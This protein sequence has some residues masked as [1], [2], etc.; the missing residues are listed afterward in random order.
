M[1]RVCW[2]IP[3]LSLIARLQDTSFVAGPHTVETGEGKQR[4][5]IYNAKRK[6][7]YNAKRRIIYNAKRRIIYN[8]KR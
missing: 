2:S 7:I 1:K 6:I 4:K 5:I 3:R 8:A